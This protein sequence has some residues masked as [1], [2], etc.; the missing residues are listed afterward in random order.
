M[1]AKDV[2]LIRNLAHE[3]TLDG[4]SRMSRLATPL[5]RK[6]LGDRRLLAFIK[7]HPDIFV[8]LNEGDNG[9]ICRVKMADEWEAKLVTTVDPKAGGGTDE[10]TPLS[11][12]NLCCKADTCQ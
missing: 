1:S 3:I 11:S 9:G 8:L 6:Q 5:T 2:A 4:I 10:V 12:K 7:V